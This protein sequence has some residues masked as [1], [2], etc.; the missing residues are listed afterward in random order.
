MC[1]THTNK[2]K[3]AANS[4]ATFSWVT[5]RRGDAICL[6]TTGWGS[7]T[8]LTRGEATLPFVPLLYVGFLT[9][10]RVEL[11][12]AREIQFFIRNYAPSWGFTHCHHAFIK[13]FPRLHWA[14][15]MHA[16]CSVWGIPKITGP[17]GQRGL[18]N[19]VFR[20]QP[21]P[22]ALPYRKLSVWPQG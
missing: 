15:F 22:G 12:G 6:H 13:H 7:L 20:V 19:P 21:N 18:R 10:L 9:I 4:I 14:A 8:C 2:L 16:T 17:W 5:Y 1:Q 3:T 11:F